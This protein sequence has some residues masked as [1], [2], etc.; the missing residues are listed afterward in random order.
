MKKEVN[1]E[2]DSD[3]FGRGTEKADLGRDDQE[4]SDD[5]GRD[6]STVKKEIQVQ[7]EDSDD[8]FGRATVTQKDTNI[9]TAIGSGLADQSTKKK[10]L[11]A[12]L[13]E[14]DS[15]DCKTYNFSN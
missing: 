11:A 14:E 15:D 3:D 2:S 6:E 1:Y 4:D 12:A 8:D 7:N 9:N 13:E 5:F 10:G